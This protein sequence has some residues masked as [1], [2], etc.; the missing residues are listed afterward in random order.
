MNRKSLQL[1]AA[2][3]TFI[4]VCTAPTAIAEEFKGEAI[5][6]II[7]GKTLTGYNVEDRKNVIWYFAE[8]GQAKLQKNNI[9]WTGKWRI[10]DT[11]RLCV[12]FRD[13]YSDVLRKEG[14]RILAKENDKLVMYGL[15]KD[16]QRSGDTMSIDEVLDGNPD[17]L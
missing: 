16:G 2:L 7:S 3:V 1:F 17:N 11:G 6:A 10:D 4:F 8:D 13:P 12:Q 14:C 15:T 5:T 9:T